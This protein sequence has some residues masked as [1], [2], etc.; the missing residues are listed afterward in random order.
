MI[1]L[2]GFWSAFWGAFVG[3][4]ADIAIIFLLVKVLRRQAEFK[5]EGSDK[6]WLK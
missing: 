4:L 3:N 2:N 5:R 6:E 1:N